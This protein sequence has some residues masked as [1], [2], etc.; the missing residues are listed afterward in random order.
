M[1]GDR[2]VY[3]RGM[4][5]LPDPT[6]TVLLDR[7]LPYFQRTDVRFSSHFQTP[8]VADPA[9]HPALISGERFAWFADPI[10]REYR[11]FGSAHLREALGATLDKLVGPPIVGDG[12]P[13][14]V[15]VVTR[16]RNDDLLVTLLHYVPTRKAME[17]DTI[18]ERMSL[19]GE[20]LT[21]DRPVEEVRL[22]GGQSLERTGP[23]SVRLPFA[24]GRLLLEVLGFW[25]S[26]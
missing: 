3:S 6:A 9:E 5:I 17:I 20:V 24:K 4:N 1:P 21:F 22:F 26:R 23:A 18:D 12:L 13:T 15:L 16:R 11:R 19:A 2:V 14:T 8:P 7:V 10:F 25:Q